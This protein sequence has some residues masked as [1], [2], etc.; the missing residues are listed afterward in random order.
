MTDQNTPKGQV[1]YD[2]TAALIY[3]QQARQWIANTAN[4]VVDSADMMEAAAADLREVKALAKRVEE[5]RTSITGP[6]NQAAKAVN[7]LF[8]P[9]AEYL[10]QAEA[11]LKTAMLKYTAEQER[12]AA[13][14][15]RVAEEQARA[16]RERLAR[17][18]AA[19]EAAAR[20]AAE[21]VRRAQAEADA[22]AAKGDQAAAA[23]AQEQARQQSEAAEQ[24]TA[25]AQAVA[26]E[27]AVVSMPPV[28]VEAA[29][30][31]GISTSKTMDFEVTDLHALV[32]HVAQ[33]P[34][35]IGLLAVD[36]VRL[37][38]QVRATG[39]R[40]NLPGVRVCEKRSMSAR[41]A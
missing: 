35:L 31:K 38:A 5:S 2:A 11:A 25:Q 20:A 3:G 23:A 30:V 14:A 12:L 21:A 9:P 28:V 29:K 1:A 17:E 40:T 19:Q 15:R 16:E 36:S 8:R 10:S 13:E 24:A 22:A 32:R 37:R 27:A 26:L 18:Q 7:D 34:E 33:N 4:Y 39:M 41:A 6:L